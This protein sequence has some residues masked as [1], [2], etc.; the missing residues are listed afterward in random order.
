M[1]KSVNNLSDLEVIV[2]FEDEQ[3]V[4]MGKPD[5]DFE[6]EYFTSSARVRSACQKDGVLSNNAHM[7][8]GQLHV[9]FDK[10]RFGK[11]RLKSRK[12]YHIPNSFFPDSKRTV[13]VEREL[14]VIIE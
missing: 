5:W 4:A 9:F 6:L 1:M 2:S 8:L 7:I 13:V 3:G 11:G 10:P 14:D 12:T